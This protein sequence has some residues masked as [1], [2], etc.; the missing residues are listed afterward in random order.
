MGILN[1]IPTRIPLDPRV[2]LDG[3]RRQPRGRVALALLWGA[4]CHGLFA[5]GVGGMIV[6]MWFGMSR[7]FGPLEGWTAALANAAL[8]AQFPIAHSLLLTAPGRRILARLAPGGHGPALATTTYALIASVQLIALF[9][10]W[11]PSG[12]IW[13]QA[14][15]GALWAITALYATAWLL[16]GKSMLDAGL[17]VQSGFL[18]WSSLLRGAR[19]LF[20][21]M[22]SGGL[23]RLVRQPIYVS[24][25]L[26]LWLVPTW[27]PDQLAVALAYTGY[28]LWAPRLK[29]RRFSE[30]YGGRFAA[31]RARTPYWLPRIMG[32]GH[33]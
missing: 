30:I 2:Y 33:G 23:F 22:P 19:P 1:E 27:T 18:G 7:G 29:E 4:L 28:C 21:D 3:A 14:Q 15:G 9:G 24:F 26:T 20:P 13:W 32:G 5:L 17:E 10:L 12:V 31:Y 16:L 6:G 8:L 25:S 11:S